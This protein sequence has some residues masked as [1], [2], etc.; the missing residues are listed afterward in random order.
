[1][2]GALGALAGAQYRSGGIDPSLALMLSYD[3]DGYLDKAAAL[4][5]I[6]ARQAG[7]LDR[8]AAGPARPRPGAHGG[9]P[10]ARRAGAEPQGRWPATSAPSSTS[11]PRPGGCST[12]CPPTSASAYDRASRSGDA[13]DCPT[14]GGAVPAS[15]RAAAAIAAARSAV[16][17]PYVWGA[18]GPSGFD[19]SGLTQW[20]YAQAG[21]GLPRT[22]QAQR[23]AG[24]QVPLDRG[25]AR[26]PRRLPRRRQPHRDVRGQRP[27][28]PRALPRRAGALRPGGHDAGLLGDAGL[29]GRR[30]GR[31]L[32][33]RSEP[34]LVGAGV[35]GRV[36]GSAAVALLAGLAAAAGER[37]RTPP[38]ATC[39]RL[40]DRRADAVLD[41][42]AGRRTARPA[43]PAEASTTSRD[44]PLSSWEYRLTASTATAAGPRPTRRA[45]LPDQGLRHA[46]PCTTRTLSLQER[47]RTVVRRRRAPREEGH[48]AALGPGARRGRAGR[49]TASSSASARVPRT[50]E[51]R[52]YAELAD[53]AVPAVRDAWPGRW[54]RQVVVLVPK[55]LDGMAGLLG[56]PA[57]G[58][59]GIAAVTTGEAGGS[60]QA[61]ADRIIV[62]PEAYGVL[63]SFGKQVVLTHE[64]THVATRARTSPATPLWLSEGFADWV[65]YRGTGRT[66]AQAAPELRRAVQRGAAARSAARRTATSA[67]AGTR[68]SSRRRTRA[69]GWPAG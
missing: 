66:A 13:T 36:R 44:V 33:V 41:R 40:L 69:A 61:P 30:P 56:A 58:Y 14:L 60:G 59:Q 37:P 52:G 15:S 7:E 67:S 62:N 27:G 12:R 39:S 64:T 6:S 25:A 54:P 4:D 23:Y 45:P 28:R 26:R 31:P 17:K 21:V 11:S 34:W 29:T 50:A 10:Q 18:N 43:A 22:S 51:L 38:P 16:G 53:R 8:P 57:S 48:R 68:A 63:G 2:R 32:P 55:S 46:P 47:G 1:M 65:G 49:R 9:H 24:R 3:P 5:R 42:D 19:C 20:A 35:G